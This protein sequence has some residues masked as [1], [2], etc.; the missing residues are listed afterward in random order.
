MGRELQTNSASS[1]QRSAWRIL[2]LLMQ[3]TRLVELAHSL[4][5]MEVES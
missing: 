4:C 5:L 2:G 1:L 3:K